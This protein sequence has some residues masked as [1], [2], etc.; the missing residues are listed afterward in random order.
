M[1]V[2]KTASICS[3][4]VP[5]DALRFATSLPVVGAIALAPVSISTSFVPVFTRKQFTDVSNGGVMY[6][7]ASAAVIFAGVEPANI[8]SIGAENV[9]VV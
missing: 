7:F 6:A 3:G 5:P 2:T 8:F 9:Q 1:C 4:V